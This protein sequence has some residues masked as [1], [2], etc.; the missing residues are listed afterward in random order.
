LNRDPKI[1]AQRMAETADYLQGKSASPPPPPT[2]PGSRE[3]DQLEF[4]IASRLPW[5]RMAVA[6]LPAPGRDRIYD[7]IE[8]LSRAMI[9]HAHSRSGAE[10]HSR[11][12]ERVLGRVVRYSLDLMQVTAAATVDP[13]PI[14]RLCQAINDLRDLKD[15]A[16]DPREGANWD[17]EVE[18][19][20]L[21]L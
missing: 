10:S 2:H 16:P 12:G 13:A 18:K 14:G 15:D 6:S 7:L 4:L 21:W 20:S 17:A 3:S 19:A 8:D 5:L 11:Y 1:A 9:A